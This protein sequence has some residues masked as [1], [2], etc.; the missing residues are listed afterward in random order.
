LVL[1]GLSAPAR[2]ADNYQ[3]DGVHSAIFFRVKHFGVGYC[4]GRFNDI[5]GSVTLDEQNPAACALE[6]RARAESIDTNNAKRDQHLKGPD[7]F[8]AREF[9]VI[10]FKSKQVKLTRPQTYEVTGDLT[11]HGVTRAV[12]IQLQR[13]GAGKDPR[14]TYRTGF[15]TSFTVKRSDFGMKFMSGGI[16]DEVWLL[17]GFEAVR[18]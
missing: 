14:G 2:A 15:E 16:G 17:V 6:I 18:Q 3:L 11:L 10:T 12:T 13:V 8:N 1:A 9:P 4:Y 5:S 7:F